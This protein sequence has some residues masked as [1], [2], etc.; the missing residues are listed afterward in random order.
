MNYMNTCN[1]SDTKTI[2]NS[3]Q[4]HWVCVIPTDTVYGLMTLPWS[5][6]SVERIFELKA[7]PWHMHLQ[8]LISWIEDI[9]TLG[10]KINE[11]AQKLLDSKYMPWAITLILW[12]DEKWIRPDRLQNRYEAAVRVP[13]SDYLLN[14][15]KHVWPI[16]ATSANRNW[17]PTPNNINE[18]VNQLCGTPDLAVDGGIIE[19]TPS[20]IVNCNYEKWWTIER[21]WV[22]SK[23]EIESYL[24]I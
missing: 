19:T 20:T 6:V 1:I 23:Q 3:L 9:K 4:K 15:I 8:I 2:I 13:N 7:R 24:N 17:I 14:I 18:I 11:T 22:I 5:P 12:F 16:L 10:L 21:E